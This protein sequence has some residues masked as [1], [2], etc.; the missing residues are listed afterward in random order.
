MGVGERHPLPDGVGTN[1]V[2]AQGSHIPYNWCFSSQHAKGYY[3]P[4]ECFC[5]TGSDIMG[6]LNATLRTRKS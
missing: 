5:F 4:A 3:H 2:F 6:A 1:G